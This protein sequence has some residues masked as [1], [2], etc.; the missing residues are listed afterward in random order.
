VQNPRDKQMADNL[1]FLSKLYP[2]KK[3]IAWGASYHFANEIGTI[4]LTPMSIRYGHRLD[5]VMK[6]NEPTDLARDLDGAVPMGKLLKSYFWNDLYSI[7]FSSFDGSF[8]MLGY[9]PTSFETITP[10]QGSIEA[11][12]VAQNY[13][14]SF[15]DFTSMPSSKFYCSAMGNVPL[16]APWKNIFD[17]HLF[18]KTS[19]PPSFP[20][21]T[22]TSPTN[23]PNSLIVKKIKTGHRSIRGR[24]I[25]AETKAP[26]SYANIYSAGSNIGVASNE[27]GEFIFNPPSSDQQVKLVFSSVGYQT[28]TLTLR[29]LRNKTVVELLPKTYLL[30]DIVVR[31][32][33][34][35]AKDI[36]K[37]AE[38]SI[39]ENYL[40]EPHN[41][42]LFYRVK[43]FTEDSV[44][45]NEEA[46]VV[47]F[48]NLGY[49][50][51]L[52]QTKNI[53]GDILQF[54]NTTKE[55]QS[56]KWTGVGSLW[57]MYG[58]DIVLDKSNVLHRVNYYDATLAGVTEFDGRKVYRIE[59]V[60]KKPGAYTVG[61]GYPSPQSAEGTIYIDVDTYAILKYECLIQRKS[62][63]N[64]RNP[65]WTTYPYGHYL[66][67]TYKRMGDRYVLSYMKRVDFSINTNTSTQKSYKDVQL[68]ELLSTNV[69]LKDL[70][71][72]QKSMI[73][74]KTGAEPKQDRDFWSTHNIVLEDGLRSYD[75]FFTKQN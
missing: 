26:V 11:S 24:V 2:N 59:F 38:K 1:I 57:L 30:S 55:T 74:I 61:F 68:F 44:V 51:G 5:S 3:I 32:K 20:D 4:E 46:T 9:S 12:L 58:H 67:Q 48:N 35:T 28:D 33:P 62:W 66:T 65:E 14:M 47:L 6:S 19:Y 16:Y 18:I 31:S 36:I 72:P 45:S 29:E 54:R 21:P 43:S 15:V 22:A 50:S 34:L 40:Q 69:I 71:I 23:A 41:Q 70:V 42:E 7:S 52:N 27:Q 17:G 56:D 39:S 63:K 73:N 75:R 13:P 64:K 60:C 37:L 8:G 10:P 49:Q 25:D 53:K